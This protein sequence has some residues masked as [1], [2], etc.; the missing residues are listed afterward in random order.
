MPH[1][2][3][4]F[5]LA[6]FFAAEFAGCGAA[7]SPS[8]HGQVTLDG[9]PVANGNIVF[10]SQD[11]KGPKASAAIENGHYVLASH[12]K[13]TPG[14]YR[15]EISW[16]KPTGRKVPSADPG[17]TIDETREAIPAKFN[18]DSTLIADMKNGEPEKNFD[19]KSN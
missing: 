8:I 7:S 15:V 19:L 5:L 9:E 14:K 13:L 6:A 18:T 3:R 12:E 1:S 2:L 17:I 16:R 10:L 4:L 11:S